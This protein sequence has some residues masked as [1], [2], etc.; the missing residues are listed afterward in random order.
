MKFGFVFTN[1][2]NSSYTKDVIYSLSISKDFHDL[3][4]VIIDN[5]SGDDDL[6][7][8]KEL[9][10]EYPTVRFIF[11]K[12]NLGYFKGLNIGLKYLRENYSD[13]QYITIGNNDLYFSVDYIDQIKRN[14]N[15]F[16]Q[17]PVISPNIIR[18]D[19]IHQNPH[20]IE[21]VSRIRY[22]I[23]DIYYSNYFLSLII[24]HIANFT[25]KFTSRKDYE[26]FSISQSIHQGYGACYILGPMFFNFFNFLWAPTFLMGEEFFLS[27]QLE[28]VRMKVFYETSIIV[29]HHD[30]AT[31]GKLPTRKLWKISKDSHN[32]LKKYLKVKLSFNDINN[33]Q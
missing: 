4:I 30:H 19:G 26:S 29:N 10:L 16:D 32:I 14:I 24:L 33:L 22:V 20:V 25:K 28:L 13:V 9:S 1:Y 8:L 12:E 7:R 2:N 27:K 11:N 5:N 15:L 6:V 21:E 31:M 23:Y 3:C 18:L 17:Y